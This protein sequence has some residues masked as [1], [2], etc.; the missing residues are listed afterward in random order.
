MVDLHPAPF[1]ELLKRIRLEYA[2]RRSVFDLPQRS[3]YTGLDKSGR[4]HPDMRV[5]LHGQ[6]AGNPLGPAA[7]PHTQ[8]AQNLLLSWLAG[9]RILEL[10]T[11]QINDQLE[12][13]RPCI[14]VP[15]VGY[16]V[17]WSQELR[18]AQ[19]L[20]QYVQGA[21]LIHMLREAPGLVLGHDEAGGWPAFDQSLGAATIFDMSVGY[22]LAG[23]TSDPVRHFIES[24][25]D[26]SA[27][28]DRLRTQIPGEMSPLR[29][30]EYPC[31]L[32][33]SIT[34]STFHG[35]PA[36]E[37]E[38]ICE[39][40]LRDIGVDVIVKMNPPML[41]S[42]R[43]EYLLHDVMGYW[44][45]RVNP[46]AYDSGLTLVEG[47]DLTQRLAC[48]ARQQ[49]R[50]FGVKFS[51]TLEVLNSGVPFPDDVHVMYLSGPPL[52]VITMSLTETFRRQVG[53]ALPISFSA[54]VDRHNAAD[55][56]SCGF[57]PVTT[58]TDLLKT[59]GYARL[60]AY[61]DRLTEA[62][63]AVGA[64]CIDDFILDV[65]GKRH[66]AEGDVGTAAWLNTPVVA[67]ACRA[68]ERYRASRNTLAPRRINAHLVLFDCLSCDKCIPVCPNAAN[69]AYES[70]EIDEG[71]YDLEV[72]PDGSIACS[73]KYKPFRLRRA[74]QIAN[75]A[76]W[77]NHCGNCDTFC[78]EYD[79]P[80]LMK[81]VFFSSRDTYGASSTHDGFV[82]ERHDS[83]MTMTG[84]IKGQE[85]SL[86]ETGDDPSAWLFDDGAVTIRI[87]NNE[88]VTLADGQS[89][90]TAPH[91]VDYSKF[92]VMK[93]LLL[94]VA[95]ASNVS[96]LTVGLGLHD[97][98]APG[99]DS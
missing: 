42:E 37:I 19:S 28:L 78:P 31:A 73:G 55:V 76:D 91:T 72:A 35:C 25:R 89:P 83:R 22:D 43:L 26:A 96:Q 79:G 39:F 6:T 77:C 64:D 12:I 40:L 58:C 9:S 15:N 29:D 32:S 4:P 81:P 49:G 97:E 1:D 87:V 53:A 14:N 18:L 13:P 27:C 3:W 56:V 24:M 90:P 54:G 61:L 86:T 8:M 20:D 60:P 57:V 70:P 2:Q 10:K 48:F 41:G 11:V 30:L 67:E 51:N 92:L 59:G 52:H 69:F 74:T 63:R 71:Y 5:Q 62:M 66:A 36:D 80:Y 16:N 99:G 94:G 93:T 98:S 95:G 45:I 38:K 65:H 84:R 17:E 44:N 33:S 82:L 68:D 47:I 21:M 34:L 50:S 75:F 7:G 23:I 85:Y 46:Q 88:D